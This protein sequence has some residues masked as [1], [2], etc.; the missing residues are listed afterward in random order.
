MEEK[1]R[2][3]ELHLLLHNI[4][5]PRNSGMLIR[6]AAAFNATSVFLVARN[7]PKS[8]KKSKL[9]ANFCLT[10]GDRG[11]ARQLDYCLLPSL[12]L[13]KAHFVE[14]GIRVVGVEIAEGAVPIE[15]YKFVQDTVIVLG[16]EGEGMSQ[17]LR[18]ICDDFVYVRQYSGRTASLNVAVCGGI[19]FHRFATF[20]GFEENKFEGEK[21]VGEKGE[22]ELKVI[23]TWDNEEEKHNGSSDPK[24]D[25]C[26]ADLFEATGKEKAADDSENSET[27]SLESEEK[28]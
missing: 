15:D 26:P 12:K 5:K 4:S 20:C 7:K 3:P 2:K 22:G 28:I 27:H 18:E 1:P 11:T 21:F 23:G 9:F 19:V 10:F 25:A 13:A 24:E 6:S 8:L 14:K 16:N 17:N